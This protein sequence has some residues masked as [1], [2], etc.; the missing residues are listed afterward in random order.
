MA[1]SNR[2]SPMTKS[3]LPRFDPTQPGFPLLLTQ[4]SKCNRYKNNKN[5]KCIHF[6]N[7]Y[8]YNQSSHLCS[9]FKTNITFKACQL[10]KMYI[11]FSTKHP[12]LFFC[13]IF[14]ISFSLHMWATAAYFPSVSQTSDW[15]TMFII[16]IILN[17]G[18]ILL[19]NSM[20]TETKSTK[21]SP[22]AHPFTRI[23]NSFSF[24]T[25]KEQQILS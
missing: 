4:P 22:I 12:N 10:S 6:L 1:I 14:H 18:V 2:A 8:S 16:T 17:N 24:Y 9:L 20:A 11:S 7:H 19:E 23:I 13:M 15:Y 3:S 21:I 25:A 5:S